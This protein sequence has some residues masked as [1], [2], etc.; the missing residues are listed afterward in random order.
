MQNTVVAPDSTPSCQ[1]F[2]QWSES[3]LQCLLGPNT[4]TGGGEG[5]CVDWRVLLFDAVSEFEKVA[6][7]FPMG[8]TRFER[9]AR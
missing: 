9:V 4:R 3:L 6:V 1:V 5:T 8:W 2:L 7:E